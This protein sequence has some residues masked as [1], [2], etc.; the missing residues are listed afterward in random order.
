MY[1]KNP[2][3][4]NEIEFADS[5]NNKRFCDLNILQQDFIEDL[6]G[7]VKKLSYIR[8][9][10]CKYNFKTDIYIK[11]DDIVKRVSIKK[12]INNSVH[13][14]PISEFIHFLIEN[15]ISQNL[16]N[17][18]LM[19]HYADGTTNGS[20]EKRLSGLEYK[21]NHQ[22][23]LD[24]INEAINTKDMLNK[25]V[26]R[27]ILK[28][29]NSYSKVDALVYGTKDDFIWLMKDEIIDIINSKINYYST[30]I[31]FGPLFCQ[32]KDRCLNYN[33]KYNKNRF[34]IQIKWYSIFD[35]YIEYKNTKCMEQAQYIE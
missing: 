8:A 25:I 13:T 2:G 32:P 28:G 14:E 5:F 3:T 12:G 22:S 24:K 1:Y 30:G 29:T 21:K 19:Y 35:D 20:G 6:F 4:D 16:I 31:H 7:K 23:E 33:P 18:Y 34:L 26:D 11:I 27:F 17:S 15:N 10:K 9:W